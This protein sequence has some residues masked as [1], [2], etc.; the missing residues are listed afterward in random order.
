MV[1]LQRT[2]KNEFAVHLHFEV[3]DIGEVMGPTETI[4]IAGD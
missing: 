4:E 2:R 3:G 1:R